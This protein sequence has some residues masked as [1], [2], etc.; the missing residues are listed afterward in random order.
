M[1]VLQFK[2]DESYDN[3]IM[4]V[5]GW[6]GDEMEWKRLESRWQKRID[7]E[8]SRSRSDQQITRFHATEINGKHGE[9]KNWDHDMTIQ[10]C[11]KLI[12][13]LSKRKIGALAVACDMNAIQEVFPNGDPDDIK[14]R[15][16]T[17]CFKTLML[18]I[19]DVLRNYFPGDTV[20]LVHDS[21]NWNSETLAAYDRI[22]GEDE[23]QIR[24]L[25]EDLKPK[26]SNECVGLQAADLFAYETFKGVKQKTNNPEAA[27][28]RG[29]RAMVNKQIPMRATWIN[30]ASAQAL[31]K[32]MEESGKYPDLESKG[33][34]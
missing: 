1:A 9:Y 12:G 13:L 30:L 31:Y 28:R 27:M 19:S 15:T 5:G 7:H 24:D 3:Q 32:L 26:T 29:A 2:F 18:E 21:G 25:F 23:L 20:L 16:Y 14:R 11:K 33:V 8:N 4:S 22:L 10:F 6:I 34:F 17:L